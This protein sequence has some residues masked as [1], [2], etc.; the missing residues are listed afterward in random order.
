MEEIAL[1]KNFPAGKTF[2]DH[3]LWWM[4]LFTMGTV[5]SSEPERNTV[6]TWLPI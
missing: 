3:Q 6:L 2:K 1:Q 4:N 5:G